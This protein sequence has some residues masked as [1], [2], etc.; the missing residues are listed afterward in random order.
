MSTKG[1]CFLLALCASLLASACAGLPATGEFWAVRQI[2]F[3]GSEFIDST[4]ALEGD[5]STPLKREISSTIVAS[6]AAKDGSMLTVARDTEFDSPAWNDTE[7][8]HEEIEN[9]V[10]WLRYASERA[11]R[12]IDL[13][14]VFVRPES[15]LRIVR[16]HEATD[17]AIIEIYVTASD[18]SNIAFRTSVRNSISTGLHESLHAS[19]AAAARKQDE[20]YLAAF[21]EICFL[22]SLLTTN[23]RLHL[24][25]VPPAQHGPRVLRRS[26]DGARR[27]L[28]EARTVIG[29]SATLEGTDEDARKAIA[30]HCQSTLDRAIRRRKPGR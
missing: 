12:P 20:E 15:R 24:P 8:L 4:S 29:G 16:R 28:Q 13:R 17:Y 1:I 30:N 18:E 14:L 5:P 11:E 22:S 25:A 19:A 6:A 9:A 2:R 26:A 3:G 7:W 27:A 21:L 23:D 10:H